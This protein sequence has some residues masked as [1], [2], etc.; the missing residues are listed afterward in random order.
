MHHSGSTILIIDDALERRAHLQG[1]CEFL[2]LQCHVFD[3]VTW[4]QEGKRFPLAG[5]GVIF[6][7][8][9]SL[10][11]S[12]SKLVAEL[13]LPGQV[14]PKV[15]VSRQSELAGESDQT[16]GLFGPLSE[17]YRYTE[18]LD[19][20]HRCS[21]FV[22]QQGGDPVPELDML[23]GQSPPIQEVK[24][25]IAQ[26]AQRDISVMITGESGTG[27][28]VVARCLHEQSLRAEGPFVPVNCGAIPGE[29]LESELFGHEKG[30]FTGAISSRAGRFELAQGGTLFLDEIG[31]MPLPMQV[32]LLRVLQERQFERVGGTKTL[33]A[34]VR[35]IAATHKDLESMIA[36]GDFREDLY[37]RLNVFPIEMP[38]L[39]E[40]L[41][42]LPLL[43]NA[44]QSRLKE[45]GIGSFR[46]HPSALES[47]LKHPWDGNVRELSN[48]MERLA[49]IY[50]DAVVGVSELPAKFRHVAEPDPER[51]ASQGPTRTDPI[52]DHP[53]SQQVQPFT[54]GGVQLPEEG[55]KLKPYLEEL[56]QSLI[57]QALDRCDY[58]V[59][60][61]ADELG[62]RRT[63]LVEKMRKYG[64]SRQ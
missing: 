63:T 9:S 14:M 17:P 33:E 46:F 24:R 54:P 12:L 1:I 55:I 10:P 60:R 6:L 49:I 15:L 23:V 41:D 57:N 50:P 56:E 44:L 59:A 7:G 21:L 47:L 53:L 37:Y 2:E 61:A 45:E 31:D 11:I 43:V 18:M 29:L 19:I 26:V 20:L 62:V 5:V 32:K 8:E 16:P 40:R 42:D 28:E 38:A 22:S 34:D 13:D 27:K 48:L 3:F 30:A 58:V 4:L 51:Y 52:S 35:I 39:R 64:I 36:A 25:L